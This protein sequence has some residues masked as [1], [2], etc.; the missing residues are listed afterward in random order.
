V[1]DSEQFKAGLQKAI[2][3]AKKQQDRDAKFQSKLIHPRYQGYQR[4]ILNPQKHYSMELF[5][6][7]SE[8]AWLINVVIGHVID[9]VI[10]Y[11]NPIS[12]KGRRGFEICL[13]DPDKKITAKQKKRAK[14][15]Q[16]FFLKTGW[17]NSLQHEDDL[18]AY[19]KKILR[20]LLT[21]DQTA[22]EKLWSRAGEILSF[23]AIDAATILRCT[24]EGLD[25][26]DKIRYV[27]MI[28][29][30]I[31]SQYQGHQILFQFDNPRTDVKHY[32]YGYSKVEQ[33]VEL[34]VSSINTFAYNAG[35]FTEDKLPRGMILL[36]GDVGMEEVEEIEDYLIDVMGPQG[37]YGASQRW[38]IPIIPSGKSGDKSSIQWQPMGNSNQEMQ[39]SRWQDF[40]NMGI[41]AL[42]GVD[43]ESTGIKSEKAAK[44]L[45]SGSAEA[46]KYSDDKGIGNALTF[47]RRHFQNILDDIDPEFSFVFHGFEQDDAKE[48]REATESEL[49]TYKSLNEIR[50]E[51]DLEPIDAKWADIPGAQNPQY[52]QLYQN[53]AGI[54]E[55]GAPEGE[56]GDEFDQGFDDFEKSVKDNVVTIVI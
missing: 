7:I 47:L 51:N 24:E 25:G 27:Q 54:G 55:E 53:E 32:G 52:V 20:D 6:R 18:P 21:L 38:G 22:A 39:Y 14:E 42:Y 37:I 10:P 48:L 4:G 23:E 43:I 29:S 3:K 19:T 31:V 26:D 8:K 46:H 56:P 2:Q 45:E 50:L 49:K 41:A 13:K 33:A 44:I 5:R 35:A 30:Q 12:D 28:E 16:E 40:L 9:K 11:M 15:I 17:D 1:V 34:I 36:S